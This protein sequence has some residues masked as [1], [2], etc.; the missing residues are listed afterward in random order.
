MEITL[1]LAQ[2]TAQAVGCGDRTSHGPQA[3]VRA[4][5]VEGRDAEV[6]R[7]LVAAGEKRKALPSRLIC[8]WQQAAA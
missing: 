6:R 8:W 3:G 7:Q 5:Q 2:G 4:S 1:E